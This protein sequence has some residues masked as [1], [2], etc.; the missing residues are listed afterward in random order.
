M[1]ESAL[2]FGLLASIF[3]V[4]IWLVWLTT[5]EGSP[6]EQRANRLGVLAGLAT[7][8][9]LMGGELAIYFLVDRWLGTFLIFPSGIAALLSFWLVGR[10]T[11]H[12]AGGG[13]E[14]SGKARALPAVES[15]TLER[16]GEVWRQLRDMA[17]SLETTEGDLINLATGDHLAWT[18]YRSQKCV[19]F[20]LAG[21]TPLIGVRHMTLDK[22]L[23]VQAGMAKVL[24]LG[25][26]G[27]RVMFRDGAR[28]Y[29][30]EGKCTSGP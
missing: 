3:V 26:G 12:A 22:Y 24:G 11:Y 17:H 21:N 13:R 23:D 15:T 5:S 30:T 8:A 25:L 29:A 18:S 19:A 1:N 28:G 4:V 7:A 6:V 9:T 20:K 27:G 10:A 14:E 2:A 16:Q